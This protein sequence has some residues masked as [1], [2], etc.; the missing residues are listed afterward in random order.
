M[1]LHVKCSLVIVPRP[2]P[3]FSLLFYLLH[4]SYMHLAEPERRQQHDWPYWLPLL[5]LLQPNTKTGQ[6]TERITNSIAS[7][8]LIQDVHL[9]WGEQALCVCVWGGEGGRGGGRSDRLWQT[10]IFCCKQSMKIND[11]NETTMYR[12]DWLGTTF[13][14][15]LQIC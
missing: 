2:I 9:G 14:Y 15:D 1:Q 8:K 12:N 11:H 13:V 7:T 4:S 10:G 5:F 6:V 3:S